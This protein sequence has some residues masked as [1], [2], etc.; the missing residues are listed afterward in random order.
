MLP[1]ILWA[2]EDPSQIKK[3][4]QGVQSEIKKIEK[5]LYQTHAQERSHIQKL[6]ELEK[7]IGEQADNL[8][9]QE[10][11]IQEHQQELQTLEQQTASLQHTNKD[12]QK[13]LSRL[14]NATFEHYHKE[15]LNLLFNPREM[16]K[17]A[18]L[19]QYY[20][21]F[22]AQRANKIRE[23]QAHLSH[24]I[25][26]QAKV[27]QKQQA[28]LLLTQD[29]K[30]QQQELLANKTERAQLLSTL[31][32]ER[33]NSEEKLAHLQSQEQHLEQLFKAIQEKIATTPTYIDPAQEF[34]KMKRR[35]ALPIQEAGAYLTK[36]PHL[37][38]A[39]A[40]KSYIQAN[41]GTPVNAIF[42]GRVVFAEWL[43]GVGLLLIIDHGDGYMS[44]Y[45]NNQKLYKSLGE[46]VSAGEMVARVGQ[47]GGHAEPGLYFEIR[48]DGEALDPTPWFSKA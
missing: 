31:T 1:T 38:K 19:N 6:T 37:K 10:N 35:L 44:L 20:V 5:N 23:L 47:S 39:K 40:K 15:K 12:H 32:N 8:L 28:I 21:H 27:K 45:G 25:L 4:L 24:V 17:L 9:I 46:W 48:K 26:L 16:S 18:R 7:Q 41:A 43:R 13:A 11:K 2:A 33:K 30:Q 29:L 3:N 14:I 36:L 22:Y 42:P 34:A